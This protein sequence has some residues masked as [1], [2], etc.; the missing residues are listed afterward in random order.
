MRPTTYEATPIAAGAV[1][2]MERAGSGGGSGGGLGLGGGGGDG[3][4]TS[5]CA[6]GASR[7]CTVV[8]T[9][10][11]V[12]PAN[13]VGLTAAR[14]LVKAVLPAAMPML[15]ELFTAVAPLSV[16]AATAN[17]T[18]T[19]ALVSRRELPVALAPMN[20]TSEAVTLSS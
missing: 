14:M 7:A 6:G 18:A 16:G 4:G 15:S 3:G 17:A 19:P 12:T 9:P 1:T 2:V 8:R 10:A 11:H 5:G 13:N 20:E